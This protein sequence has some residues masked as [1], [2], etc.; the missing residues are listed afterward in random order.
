MIPPARARSHQRHHANTRQM[1]RLDVRTFEKGA[2]RTQDWPRDQTDLSGVHIQSHKLRRNMSACQADGGD[3]TLQRLRCSSRNKS[4]ANEAW[5]L[6]S[7]RARSLLVASTL[8]PCRFL[9]CAFVYSREG[10][11]SLKRVNATRVNGHDNFA[12]LG[13]NG[14]ELSWPCI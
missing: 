11:I 9:S 14:T 10:Q 13:S 8:D 3:G 7:V 1:R 2:R 6:C 12:G 4:R 5:W